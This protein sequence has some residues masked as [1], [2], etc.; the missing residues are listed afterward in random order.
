MKDKLFIA[1]RYSIILFFLLLSIVCIILRFYV[2]IHYA[3]TP[4]AEIPSWAY[5]FM[6]NN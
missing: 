3:S 2:I 6:T 5:V 1:M 4:L